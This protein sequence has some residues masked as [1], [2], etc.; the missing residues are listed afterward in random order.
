[1][2]IGVERFGRGPFDFDRAVRRRVAVFCCAH[3]TPRRDLAKPWEREG[4]LISQG[5]RYCSVESL[6]I[7][8]RGKLRSR[9]RRPST[10]LP[11]G[12]PE[13]H[14][15]RAGAHARHAEPDELLL[16]RLLRVRLVRPGRRQR[17]GRERRKPRRRRRFGVD[18]VDRRPH[19]PRAG[20]RFLLRARVRRQ[21]AAI[22]VE[23]RKVLARKLQPCRCSLALPDVFT[24]T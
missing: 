23:P 13:R 17:L 20:Y 21:T 5:K 7:I 8:Y 24:E 11:R 10:A 4:S 9:E 2:M 3:S 18:L 1:M 22:V 16:R 19:A 15:H 14:D 6:F 12:E